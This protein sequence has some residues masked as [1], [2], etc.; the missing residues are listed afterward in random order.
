MSDER[1]ARHIDAD[2]AIR[3]ILEATAPETG[4][5]FFEALVVGLSRALGT[6]AAWVTEYLPERRALRALAFVLGGEMVREYE[7]AV[8]GTP[9][10]DAI[11]SPR[12][13]LV[14][15]RLV[16]LYPRDPDLARFGAVSYLGA[17]LL[18][19]LGRVA[20][21]LAVMD[22]RPLEDEPRVRAVFRLFA[23]R[24]AAE[25]RRW[26]AEAD[27]RESER[28]L[29]NLI[30]SARD[31]ILRLDG[32]LRVT[33]ANPAA[34]K[35]F[36]LES[37]DLVSRPFAGFLAEGDRAGFAGLVARLSALPP[38]E[39]SIWIPN[40]LALRR[41]TGGGEFAAEVTISRE[42]GAGG[43]G[44]LLILRN[45]DERAE[46]ERRLAALAGEAAYLREEVRALA[47]ADAPLGE[48]EPWALALREVR[49]VAPTNAAV[50]VL[51]ETGT[52]K[53]VIAR[54]IHALSPRREKPLIKVNCAAL[55]AALIESEL[56]GHERGA[57][58]G[59]TRQR[60]GRFA[61]A[62]GGTLF[63][64][65]I[66]ELPLDLQPKLLRA[67]QEGEFE[68]VGGTVTR[69]VDVR[70]LSATN[71]DLER[72]VREGRFR[73]D[74]YYR[75]AVFPVRLPPLRERGRD[76]LL[77]AA[78]LA[79]RFSRAH[80]RRVAPLSEADERALLAY[81][82]PGNVRELSNVIERAVI[83]AR[84]GRLDLAR[85]LRGERRAESV[86]EAREPAAIRT[87]AEMRALERA[88]LFRAL[89]KTGWKVAGDDGA[90]ALLGL[91]AS[92]LASRIK[93]FGLKRP[94][95]IG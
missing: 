41:A 23:E 8:S 95:G 85:G 22:S 94:P 54:A 79:E 21:H 68:P 2:A 12:P 84:D 51:G 52:G 34:E 29:R 72:E 38:G 18:D 26:R 9:C 80:G 61:L 91:S 11:A 66:G 24:A 46:A 14:S 93:S 48:S 16:A 13:H 90:A 42:A 78:A 33:L 17:P 81:P 7:Y 28:G 20:G 53:E 36:G 4:E 67:V 40:G 83:T 64:D 55:P 59:A 86:A 30:E 25:L 50:L 82:W 32:D 60:E 89:E 69:R 6:R 49:E 87:D 77:L 44:T 76:V 56:F 31:A 1:H 73:E 19:A 10:E 63:L 45:R 70:V 75:L 57:F 35:L 5:R 37:R 88:N 65:E 92:T 62:D 47:G 27:L 43:G 3:E 58:T 71:R 15:D 39:R 74:L